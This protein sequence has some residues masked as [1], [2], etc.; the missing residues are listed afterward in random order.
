MGAGDEH[1][2]LGT[3]RS[4]AVL[5]QTFPQEVVEFFFRANWSK[6]ASG[7]LAKMDQRLQSGLTIS[8]GHFSLR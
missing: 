3:T 7:S 2:R 4:G 5:F 6:N 1:H 8:N